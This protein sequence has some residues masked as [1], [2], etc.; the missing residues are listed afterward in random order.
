MI[1]PRPGDWPVES[2]VTARRHARRRASVAVAKDPRTRYPPPALEGARRLN[3]HDRNANRNLLAGIVVGLTLTVA[4]GSA[5]GQVQ[6]MEIAVKRPGGDYKTFPIAAD[7]P[8]ICREAC[9]REAKCVAWTFVQAGPKGESARCE[10]KSSVPE[11][12]KDGCCVA[13]LKGEPVKLVTQALS[14]VGFK[15][16]GK[17]L[18]TLSLDKADPALCQK[19]CDQESKCV[20]WTLT[21]GGDKGAVATCFLKAER[22]GRERDDASVSGLRGDPKKKDDLRLPSSNLQLP[23]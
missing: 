2:R 9:L 13:G 22:K 10:L 19:A 14:F 5:C 8:N 21:Q 11:P 3:V 1:V 12:I 15:L 20:A 16:V 6:D 18:R 17:D 7:D 4:A 23:H